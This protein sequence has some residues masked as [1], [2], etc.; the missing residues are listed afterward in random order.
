MQ[1]ESFNDP[2]VAGFL[3][4]QFVCVKVDRELRPDIDSFYQTYT[5]ASTGTGGW[6]LNVFLLTD[7]LP[8]LGWAYLP[9]HA[10]ESAALTI[11][12]AASS[13]M[14]SW[15]L[16]REEAKAAGANAMSL[17][18]SIYSA[19]TSELNSS[20]VEAAT[21]RIRE[22]LDLSFGGL[23]EGPKHPQTAVID[24]LL[25]SYQVTKE[26]W[27][28]EA[29][30]RWVQAIIGGGL[31]DQQ[32][33]GVFRYT[34]DREWRKPSPE[35]TPGDQGS[36]LS[37]LALLHK[38]DDDDRY[39]QAAQAIF[40]FLKRDLSRPEGGYYSTAG[41]VITSH[42]AIIARGLTEAGAAFGDDAMMKSGL[43]TL[44]WILAAC[45]KGS[46]LVRQPDDRSVASLRF[47]EDYAATTAACLSAFEHTRQASL[48]TTAQ[49]LQAKAARIFAG[50]EGFAAISGKH[51]LPL[52]PLEAADTPQPAA[53]SLLAENAIR[54]SG[55][56]NSS[57]EEPLV[58]RA[59]AQFT[60]TIRFAPH[61]AG[62]ALRVI[63]MRDTL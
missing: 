51:L 37:T 22:M 26:P 56:S 47:L 4:R 31:F 7:A 59:L 63:R 36:L 42:N 62:H 32:G 33:G 30:S 49:R 45:L 55:L 15:V 21:G 60:R 61:L 19:D 11:M 41:N 27:Q 29:A 2:D 1:V 5:G 44:G 58:S 13:A 54:M 18:R 14:E 28:L 6:P 46:D 38:V 50:P 34:E 17:M 43:D 57:P 20:D 48:L 35:K 9:R 52:A 53:P 12:D 23:G 8:F 3:N 24:F 16:R 40:E 10:S 25:A 39:R